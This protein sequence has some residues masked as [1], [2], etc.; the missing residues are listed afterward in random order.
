LP[1]QWGESIIAP[2]YKKGNKTDCRN[3]HGI[4]LLSISYKILFKVLLSRLSSYVEEIIGD[5]QCGFQYSRTTTDQ[6][7]AFIRYQRKIGVK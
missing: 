1:D 3:Y 6:I 4:S 7:F 5:H 2:V